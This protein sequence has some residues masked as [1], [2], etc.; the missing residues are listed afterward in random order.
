MLI[1]KLNGAMVLGQLLLTIIESPPGSGGLTPDTGSKVGR[2]RW[3][4]SRLVPAVRPR[5][6]GPAPAFYKLIFISLR[7][8]VEVFSSHRPPLS[9][10]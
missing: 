8:E 2:H 10:L 5:M 6:A 1:M 9:Q 3:H 4:S 7:A